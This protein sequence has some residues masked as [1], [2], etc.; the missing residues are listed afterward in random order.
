[1]VK[2]FKF[3]ILL[4]LVGATF[5]QPVKHARKAFR[6]QVAIPCN[7]IPVDQRYVINSERTE[8]ENMKL[9]GYE[10]DKQGR[11]YVTELTGNGHGG[12]V[13]EVESYFVGDAGT[14]LVTFPA[15]QTQVKTKFS[16]MVNYKKVYS[17]NLKGR[18]TWMTLQTVIDLP[19]VCVISLQADS[20]KTGKAF[21]DYIE[22]LPIVQKSMIDTKDGMAIL[23]TTMQDGCGFNSLKV[24]GQEIATNSI[25]YT[26]K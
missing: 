26:V 3:I 18:P 5:A 12:T 20:D 16:L 19:A 17:I 2:N 22:L 11:R 14:Y 4:F 10:I 24:D 6:S 13:G 1:M 21:L 7:G 25:Y 15:Y 8:V 9:I 23:N